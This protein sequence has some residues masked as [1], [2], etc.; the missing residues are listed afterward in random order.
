[1]HI[2]SFQIWVWFLPKQKIW[3]KGLSKLRLNDLLMWL[4][5][6]AV[7]HLCGFSVVT[8][9]FRRVSSKQVSKIKISKIL[10]PTCTEVQT[11]LH[12]VNQAFRNKQTTH[13]HILH[14]SVTYVVRYKLLDQNCIIFVKPGEV[15]KESVRYHVWLNRCD[16]GSVLT[17]VWKKSL[18]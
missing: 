2:F 11:L 8:L 18:L 14:S 1:M 9:W 7:S 12:I 17:V 13:S 3:V 4:W 16:V 5:P 10:K 6:A 15:N